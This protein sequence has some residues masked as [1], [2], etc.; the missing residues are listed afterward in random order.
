MGKKLTRRQF[1][2]WGAATAVVGTGVWQWGEANN[3]TL[4]RR[5]I[6]LPRWKADGF[7]VAVLSDF[8]ANLP[9]EGR[10]AA[11]AIA[12]AI[13]ERPDALLLLGDYVHKNWPETM[14]SLDLALAPL[15][16]AR[17]P[18]Y[19]IMGNHDYWVDA[20]E[21]II[22]KLKRLGARL[23]RNEIVVQDDVAIWGIDDGLEARDRHDALGDRL[24]SG[25][26]LAMFH[27]PDFVSRVDRRVGLML[28]GHSHGGQICLPFGIPMH[29]PGGAR[30]YRRGYYPTAR[31]P[32]HVNR[33][34]GTVGP[35]KR[36]F[37]SPE[38]GIYTLRNGVAT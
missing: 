14:P 26:V 17:M 36:A 30:V 37:C 22:A 10:R 18:V 25:S 31:V 2:G 23:L 1:F 28:S 33:G 34:I 29:T 15:A 13:A 32:L 19:A 8:H 20:T 9:H 11:R 16:D 12:M 7:R 38:I 35:N 5:T 21:E 6:Q 24:D 3:L 4:E 27:E